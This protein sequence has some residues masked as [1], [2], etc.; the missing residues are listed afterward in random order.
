MVSGYVGIL[1]T[2]IFSHMCWLGR[3]EEWPYFFGAG[4]SLEAGESVGACSLFTERAVR[5]G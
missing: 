2:L 5:R 4:S 1:R 3:G